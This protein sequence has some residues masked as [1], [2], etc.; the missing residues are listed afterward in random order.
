M[1]GA[2][3]AASSVYFPGPIIRFH[4]FEFFISVRSLIS[5][6]DGV[7][8]DLGLRSWELMSDV[9]YYFI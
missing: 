4:V 9:L 2:V 5:H 7:G 6:K 3:A 8:E 1:V